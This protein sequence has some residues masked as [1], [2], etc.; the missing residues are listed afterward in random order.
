M[1]GVLGEVADYITFQKYEE[2]GL[3][4]AARTAHQTL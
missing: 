4:K 2:D 3:V 1:T